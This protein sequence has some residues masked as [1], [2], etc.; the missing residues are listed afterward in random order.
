MMSRISIHLKKQHREGYD[1]DA[2]DGRMHTREEIPPLPPVQMM[3]TGFIEN[4]RDGHVKMA[5]GN[6]VP[7]VN[8]GRGG[9]GV[10][11]N[12]VPPES[13]GKFMDIEHTTLKPS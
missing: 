2:D 3:T 13:D 10:E 9:G 11:I 8:F 5:N 12:L 6:N 1:P 4:T 7:A